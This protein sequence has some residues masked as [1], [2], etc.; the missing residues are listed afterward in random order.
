MWKIFPT[1]FRDLVRAWYNNMKLGSIASFSDL[2]AKLVTRFSTDILAKKSSTEL[3]GIT[4][5][6]D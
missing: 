3:F 6:E 1:T 2:C 5:V 4:Q